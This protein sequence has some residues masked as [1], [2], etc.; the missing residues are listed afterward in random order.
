MKISI[1]NAKCAIDNNW[2]IPM[3]PNGDRI[4]LATNVLRKD[5]MTQK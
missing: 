4:K 3:D 1:M 2:S 5:G